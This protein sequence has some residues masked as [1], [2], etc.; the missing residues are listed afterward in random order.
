MKSTYQKFCNIIFQDEIIVVLGSKSE[1][2][3]ELQE[4]P[5]TTNIILE[6]EI[7]SRKQ[8]K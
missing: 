6:F 3:Q 4:Y 1:I 8:E 5:F 7:Y 2:I